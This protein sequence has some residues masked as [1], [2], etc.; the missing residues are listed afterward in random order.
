MPTDPSEAAGD[1]EAGP[2]AHRDAAADPAPSS[3]V[4]VSFRNG[5][6]RLNFTMKR[7][8]PNRA[9]DDAPRIAAG[10]AEGGQPGGRWRRR[11][12]RLRRGLRRQPGHF[13]A[14]LTP[15]EP[16]DRQSE[17][18]LPR[19]PPP[20][21]GPGVSFW[22]GLGWAEK[23]E[24]L[25]RADER[26]F[27][28]GARLMEEGETANHVLVIRE[29][30]TKI[31]VDD[32]G[33]ERTIAYR[34]PGQIIGERAALQVSVR[35]ATVVATSTV[36]ALAMHTEDFAAFLSAHPA[37]LDSVERQVYFRLT[38]EPACP[39]PGDGLA[40]AEA[41]TVPA[42]GAV[43]PPRPACPPP[44]TGENCTVI[45]TDVVQFGSPERDDADRLVIR[46]E[47]MAMTS[48]A[49]KAI[50]GE[51]FWDDRGDGLLVVVPPTVAT[52]RVLEYLLVAL[53]IALKRHNGDGPPG[54]RFQLRAALDVGAVT[55]DD[56]GVSG[57]VIIGTARL[58]DA[59]VLKK[60]IGGS[61]APLAMIVS[62]FVY[63]NTVRHIRHIT[64]PRSYSK[65]RVRVKEASMHAWMSLVGSPLEAPP[66]RVALL[67][68][69]V[70]EPRRDAS[71]WR[72]QAASGNVGRGCVA[73][74]RPG[75]ECQ[76]RRQ[77]QGA[78]DAARQRIARAHRGS[79]G[80]GTGL[81]A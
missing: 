21:S 66:R 3:S 2:V 62:D 15:E 76:Q 9:R 19:T 72:R 81:R 41:G 34:G 78:A 44:F 60:A 27:A 61:D 20:Y 47:L 42:D 53:P 5:S 74:A 31:C 4:A 33:K 58:L 51:C 18:E 30:Q 24:F 70:S 25:S 64:D 68:M 65:V 12:P 14:P 49:L 13:R 7:Y 29:G 6:C 54:T 69:W 46:R 10:G 50:W 35:S 22:D 75:R 43:R 39:G 57:Q 45:F 71:A 48:G 56:T 55:S 11:W 1:E 80:R 26:T 77:R 38:E 52:A 23:R 40:A 73:A 59:P 16:P 63:Q 37:V 67:A 36:R 79:G 28:S 8:R 17:P 32:H